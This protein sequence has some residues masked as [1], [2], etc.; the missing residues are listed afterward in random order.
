MSLP[1]GVSKSGALGLYGQLLRSPTLRFGTGGVGQA[2]GT[3]AQS[4]QGLGESGREL[5][6]QF[7]ESL[8]PTAQRAFI[9]AVNSQGVQAAV[10]QFASGQNIEVA[11]SLLNALSLQRESEAGTLD[12][13]I[14]G[15]IRT[16]EAF[17]RLNAKIEEL[18]ALIATKALPVI[19]ALGQFSPST[20]L[21]V[22]AG[23]AGL[24]AGRGL[25]GRG[26]GAGAGALANPF[27]AA[28]AVG[29]GGALAIDHLT[30]DVSLMD[31][32]AAVDAARQA[33]NVQASQLAQIAS[34]QA[35]SLRG[36]RQAAEAQLAQ[37]E[38]DNERGPIAR[39]LGF[40]QFSDEAEGHI[41]SLRD[42]IRDLSDQI[43]RTAS[44]ADA[45]TAA[46]QRL[47]QSEEA[48]SRQRE[49]DERLERLRQAAVE[50]AMLSPQLA[51]AAAQSGLAREQLEASFL[52]PFESIFAPL[53]EA[54][55]D[56]QR[57]IRSEIEKQTALLSLI[58][59]STDA[60]KVEAAG[61]RAQIQSLR[62]ES[63]SQS[64][65]AFSLAMTDYA[66]SLNLLR[67]QFQVQSTTPIGVIG[68]I[69]SGN[70]LAAGIRGEITRLQEI[71]HTLSLSDSA[72]SA[73]E[74]ARLRQ[75]MLGL[76][77]E[78]RQLRMTSMR[79][80]IDGVLA[81]ASRAGRFEKVLV[82]ETQNLG[83]ALERGLIASRPFVTGRSG[84][85]AVRHNAQ[86]ITMAELIAGGT[87]APEVVAQAM[88][89]ASY[90]QAQA[91]KMIRDFG[92]E[93]RAGRMKHYEGKEQIL[94]P[95]AQEDEQRSVSATKS[96]ASIRTKNVG[97]NQSDL[98]SVA[99]A[100][101]DL[102]KQG[103]G[104]ALREIELLNSLINAQNEGVDYS[105]HPGL[106]GTAIGT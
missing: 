104:L 44:V 15:A 8:E 81:E 80:L 72:E 76:E 6:A 55:I 97:T 101:L 9:Q 11:D 17:D 22:G 43:G 63:A 33:A 105:A 100:R 2:T 94:N 50:R 26:I 102:L 32:F 52:R 7:V 74:A 67:L 13:L 99:K 16:T 21:G 3:L 103:Q 51:V 95:Q 87:P 41:Q 27:G 96:G 75:I 88:S 106:R 60:G 66:D 46:T 73:R 18:I 47:N 69:N 24:Y 12:P 92:A 89:A 10:G 83:A 49:S 14:A 59:T 1:S 28:A 48:L 84:E 56:L 39:T 36:Q 85:D 31:Q 38:S 62:N 90:D 5:V 79:A 29:I 86:P 70:A 25:I 34:S 23:A 30:H 57:T 4:V 45:A 68:A 35:D 42:K 20:L 37:Y 54:Q 61:I 93:L 71:V 65:A 53:T 40:D 98:V 58:D 91:D 77:L 64:R 19:E 78:L 82:T